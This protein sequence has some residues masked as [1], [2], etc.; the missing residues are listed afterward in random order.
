MPSILVQYIKTKGDSIVV[1]VFHFTMQ[2]HNF[3]STLQQEAKI[4]QTLQKI[5]GKL[6][7]GS[8]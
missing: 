7:L 5:K 3:E 8:P 1:K 6:P 4:Q 2:D